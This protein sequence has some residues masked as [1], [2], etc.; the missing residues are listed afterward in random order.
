[1]M[2]VSATTASVAPTPM[3]A[4]AAV[5]NSSSLLGP[6]DW[7]DVSVSEGSAKVAGPGLE[8]PASESVEAA[9][10]VAHVKESAAI[11][12]LP[13]TV[14]SARAVLTAS[15]ALLLVVA[16][17]VVTSIVSIMSPDSIL[18]IEDGGPAAAVVETV[19]EEDMI[20]SD[21]VPAGREAGF[22]GR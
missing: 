12:G 22:G 2:A 16:T 17:A 15:S 13:I 8:L 11:V 18:A 7:E 9:I 19:M 20:V 6:E 5:S 4:A 21:V 3:P 1:M 10:L 14:A